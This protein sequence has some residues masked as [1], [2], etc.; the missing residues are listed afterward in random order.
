MLKLLLSSNN[1]MS[2][3]ISLDHRVALYLRHPY[4]L[5]K[6]IRKYFKQKRLEKVLLASNP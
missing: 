2:K 1:R 5:D 3:E 6:F 4:L